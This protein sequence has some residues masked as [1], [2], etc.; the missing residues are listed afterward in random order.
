[1]SALTINVM[2]SP[3]RVPPTGWLLSWVKMDPP[4]VASKLPF[5]ASGTSQ[6][7]V[8]QLMDTPSLSIE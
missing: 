7:V 3:W 8:F 2:S 4:V 1:M 6:S 5:T